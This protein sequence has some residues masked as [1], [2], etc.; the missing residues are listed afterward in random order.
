[1]HPLRC[2]LLL[3]LLLVGCTVVTGDATPRRGA[4]PG[5][6]GGD[7]GEGGGNSGGDEAEKPTVAAVSI[8]P[9][10]P[11][12]DESVRC[13]ADVS[14][15]KTADITYEWRNVSRDRRLGDGATLQLDPDTISPGETLRCEVTAQNDAG[16]ASDAATAQPDCGFADSTS[17]ADVEV[18]LHILFR[19]WITEDLAPG[20]GGDPW[21]WDGN[22]PAWLLDFADLLSDVLDLLAELIPDADLQAAAAAAATLE[23]ILLLIDEHAPEL[24]AGTVPPDPNLYAYLMDGE[25]ELWRADAV[26]LPYE[27]NDSYEI[28]LPLTLDL[29]GIDFL[30]VDMEDVDLTVDDNMGDYLDH[31]SSPLALSTPLL[32]EGAYCPIVYTNPGEETIETVDAL[33]PSSI[34]WMQIDTRAGG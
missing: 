32:V 14:R 13:D 34:L 4:D 17:L 8:S 18:D 3:S 5:G 16:S 1:M 25:S 11:T 30:L 15:A 21:D 2:S 9:R 29:R 28:V 10:S 33:V 6:D 27:W 20:Y 23:E 12:T 19:P 31:H 26:D 7:G 22:V 24:L